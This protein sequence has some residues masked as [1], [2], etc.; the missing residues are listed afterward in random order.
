[1]PYIQQYVEP[2][3]F[4]EHNGVTVYHAY[5][6]GSYYERYTYHFTTDPEGEDGDDEFEFDVRDLPG[7]DEKCPP[8]KN[9]RK[10]D[11]ALDKLWNEYHKNDVLAQ[12]Q[13]IAIMAAIDAGLLPTPDD[14]D[15]E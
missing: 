10:P 6:D 13:K 9:F 7:F 2:D 1:M 3:V 8:R 5:E 11:P 4:L 14:E 12:Q 15:D